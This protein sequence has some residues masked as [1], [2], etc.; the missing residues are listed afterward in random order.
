MQH[1][2]P[3]LPQNGSGQASLR[4]HWQWRPEWA[5]DRPCLLWYLTFESQPELTRKAEQAQARLRGVSTVDVVPAA[6]LHLTLDDVG[7]A[8]ELAP[9]EVEDV[10]ATARGAVADWSPPPITLGPVASM[11]DAVVLRADPA[12]DL[13][14]LRGRLRAVTTTVLGREIPSRL[15]PFWPHVTLA[16]LNDSCAASSVLDP[17]APVSV[18]QVVVAAPQVTLA[19]V[20]RCEHHYRWTTRAEI[21]L[22]R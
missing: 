13:G 6:W 17:L 8:D 10:I 21:P 12:D 16:Y 19:S 5:S 9:E 4:D 15:R 18:E 11:G 22:G 14:E 3:S 20:T 7:F 2:D 1:T